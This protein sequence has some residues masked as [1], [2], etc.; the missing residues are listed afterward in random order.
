MHSCYYIKQIKYNA[1]LA[2]VLKGLHV[3]TIRALGLVD[4]FCL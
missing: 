4:I 1:L 2:F 3:F